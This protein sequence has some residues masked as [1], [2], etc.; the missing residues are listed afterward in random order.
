MRLGVEAALVDGAL[1]PGDVEIDDGVIQAVGVAGHGSGIAAPGFV[2]LQV[3]GFA[4][5]DLMA[6]DRD[7]YVRVGEALLEA[8]TTAFQ[9]TFVTAPEQAHLAALRAIPADAIGPRIIGAHL[10]GPFLSPKRLGVHDEGG[11]A[12]PDLALLRRLL[13]AAH[14]SQVTLAPELPGAFE[15]IDELVARGIVVS[16]GHTDATAAEAHLAFDRGVSTVTHLFNA[17]RHST[18]RDPSIALAAL[19]RQDVI[20]QV[21]VD[22]HHVASDTVLVAWQAATD[23]FA[24]VTDAAPAAGMGD[25]EFVLGGRRIHASDGVVRGPEGQLAGSALTMIDAVRNLHGLGVGLQDALRA[26]AEVP[27][28]VVRRPDLGRLIPGARA[29]V[30]VLDD[31]LD[32][33]RVLVD[34]GERVAR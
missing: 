12:T 22:L 23:R 15:L 30:V 28:R 4:G 17:M 32:V 18:P 34:G 1:L 11:L 5:V 20:V 14:V 25:G 19:A 27:A 24:L 29:D 2:D 13:D 6:A 8:G 3:N 9:P 31:R 7:G 21:I 10:E 26:A 33:R 16:A